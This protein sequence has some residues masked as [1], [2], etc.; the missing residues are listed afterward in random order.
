LIH[1][2]RPRT[3]LEAL[4][5]EKY[6]TVYTIQKREKQEKAQSVFINS[7]K[8]KI[9]SLNVIERAGDLECNPNL[10]ANC[11]SELSNLINLKKSLSHLPRWYEGVVL[12]RDNYF[13]YHNIKHD[14][15]S[16][17]FDGVKY[18]HEEY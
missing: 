4:K 13:K 11:S 7:Q 3:Y 14:Y 8:T 5:K 9:N 2:V 6:M 17:I 12:V 18:W 1:I 10:D 15:K 16:I